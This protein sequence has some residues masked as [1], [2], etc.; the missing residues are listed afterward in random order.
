MVVGNWKL[1]SEGRHLVAVARQIVLLPLV[2]ERVKGSPLQEPEAVG[3][4]KGLQLEE[5]P[6]VV[7]MVMDLQHAAR[8]CE[9]L[10]C[11]LSHCG[12]RC[13]VRAAH[14]L[15]RRHAQIFCRVPLDK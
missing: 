5:P 8:H 9:M 6:A 10:V 3:T 13:L 12:H 14:E 1:A 15:H 11:S 2:A 7:V 4:V